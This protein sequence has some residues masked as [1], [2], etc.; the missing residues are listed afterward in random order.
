MNAHIKLLIEE[1]LEKLSDQRIAEVLDFVEFL[2]KRDDEAVEG[3]LYLAGVDQTMIEWTSE[4]DEL[5][6]SNRSL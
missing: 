4:E 1:K 5:A 3:R 2:E 6:F